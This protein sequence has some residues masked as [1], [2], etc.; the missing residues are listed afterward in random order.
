[1]TEN[2]NYQLVQFCKFSDR[3]ALLKANEQINTS[4]QLIL[5]KFERSQDEVEIVYLIPCQM[6]MIVC[7]DEFSLDL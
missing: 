3:P 2:Q 6:A 1:M 5:R 4:K 7:E